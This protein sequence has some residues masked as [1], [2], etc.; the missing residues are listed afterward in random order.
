MSHVVWLLF[1][2]CVC[3]WTFSPR[4]F[5]VFQEVLWVEA[6]NHGVFLSMND[7]GWTGDEGQKLHAD[8]P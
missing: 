6:G 4:P 8:A 2:M 3:V 5:D 1:K 7:E